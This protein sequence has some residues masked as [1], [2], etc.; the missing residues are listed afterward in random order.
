MKCGI[1]RRFY[2]DTSGISPAACGLYL[3]SET[4]MSLTKAGMRYER[5]IGRKEVDWADRM[6]RWDRMVGEG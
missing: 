5:S 3:L 6:D 2:V 4:S 1:S